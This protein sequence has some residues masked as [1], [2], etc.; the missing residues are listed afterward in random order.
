MGW[1]YRKSVRM[2]PLN[3]NL[4][5]RG[6]GTSWGV[7]GFRITRSATGRRYMTFSV[8]G[9]G[10]SW[11]KPLGFRRHLTPPPRQSAQVSQ[12]RGAAPSPP[13]ATTGVTSGASTSTHPRPIAM[14]PQLVDGQ[15]WWKQDGLDD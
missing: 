8:P 4:S 10:L 6:V 9:T 1:R 15:P 13:P 11:H 2:G 3:I 5:R 14:Q 7:P 12:A